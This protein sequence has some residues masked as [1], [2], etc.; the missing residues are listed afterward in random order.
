MY[1]V[2]FATTSWASGG[3]GKCIGLTLRRP[4]GRR[5]KDWIVFATTRREFQVLA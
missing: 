3:G 1:W 5:G 4:A 2:G